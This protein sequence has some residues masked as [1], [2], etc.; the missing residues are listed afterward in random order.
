[1]QIVRATPKRLY[2]TDPRAWA[3]TR[4]TDYMLGM[5]TTTAL[6]TSGTAGQVL[7]EF[8]WTTTSLAYVA[9]S[10]ADFMTSA[11]KGIPPHIILADA[12]DQVLSPNI[13]GDWAAMKAVGRILGY[14]PTAL[15]LEVIAAFTTASNNEPSTGFGFVEDDAAFITAASAGQIAGIS[16]NGTNFVLSNDTVSD[17]GAAIDTSWHVWRIKVTSASIEWFIDGTSQGTIALK[18]DE[19]PARFGAGVVAAG[20]NDLALGDVHIWYE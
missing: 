5:G 2:V 18:A 9:G 16:S 11:D 15:N 3:F 14:D 1:M 8:G 17:A 19:W 6:I 12:S 20:A 13:F 4:G 7:S 10:G